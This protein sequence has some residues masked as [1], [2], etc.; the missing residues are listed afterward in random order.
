MQIRRHSMCWLAAGL[1]LIGHLSTGA[2]ANKPVI[3][4]Q[5]P[6]A[7]LDPVPL[8]DGID[9]GQ[10]DV[11]LVHKDESSGNLFIDNKTGKA[12]NVELPDAFI[13]VHVLNQDFFGTGN[14]GIF[15]LGANQS[16][17]GQSQGGQVTGGGTSGSLLPGNSFPGNA[18]PGN[19]P[20][21]IFS[22]PPEKIVRAPVR[23]VCL[24]HGRPEPNARME[25]RVFPV[26]RFSRDPVLHE[27]LA[28][29]AKGRTRQ[30][31]AQAAAWHLADGMSWKELARLKFRRLGGLPDAPH[32]SARELA[33]AQRLV[34]KSH[35]QAAQ[36]SDAAKTSTAD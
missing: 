36:V 22:I 10:L 27:L 12:I 13:G 5:K 15:D 23:S 3:P 20:G 33:E 25:Y 8:F 24:E 6:V 28:A 29:V 35:K 30:K 4:A 31:A 11:K 34:K 17:G 14:N 7:E 2:A 21:P 16:G 9:A 1:F 18:Q 26:E 32:F 19:G